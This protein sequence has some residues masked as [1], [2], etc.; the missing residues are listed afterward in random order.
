LLI[1]GCGWS[2]ASLLLS[3]FSRRTT[4]D[5]FIGTYNQRP[6][7]SQA[8]FMLFRL[9]MGALDHKPCP[10]QNFI[11]KTRAFMKR[12]RRCDVA[13]TSSSFLPVDSILN[14][15]IIRPTYSTMTFIAGPHACIRKT[16]STIEMKAVLA[17]A[18]S[19]LS[20][21]W[22]CLFLGSSFRNSPSKLPMKDK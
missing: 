2:G 11:R 19:Y 15:A 14:D 12:Y 1:T 4:T 16:M 21:W 17:C 18:G 5:D 3:S 20:V 10:D 22:E 13:C 7:S 6:V 8:T 9:C